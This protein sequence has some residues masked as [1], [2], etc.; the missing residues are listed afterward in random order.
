MKDRFCKKGRTL[1]AAMC[2]LATCGLTYSCSDDYDLDKTTPSWLGKS[3]Y[4]ELKAR[5]TFT[6]YVKL[7]DDLDYAE[8]LSKTGSK[9]LFVAND[10]AFNRFFANNANRTDDWKNA[11]SYDRLTTAQKKIILNSSMINNAYLMELMSNTSGSG[12]ATNT[13]TLISKGSC[14]RRESALAVTDSIPFFYGADLPYSYNSTDND[15]WA[16]FRSKGI[17]LAMDGTA[18]MMT[19]FLAAQMSAQGITDQDFQIITGKTRSASDAYIYGSK[20]IEQDITCQN[21]YI[22]VL[23]NVLVTPNN[24]AEVLRT[25]GQTSLFSHMVERFSAPFYNSTLTTSFKLN[26]HENVDSVFEKRYFSAMSQGTSGTAAATLQKDPNN[27]AVTS[28]LNFDP[29]WNQYRNTSATMEADMGA[30]FVPRD[31][32]LKKYFLTGGGKFLLDAYADETPYT[33]ANLLHNIDQIPLNVIQALLNNL[34][35]LSFISTVPSKFETVLDDAQDPMGLDI[36][37]VDTVLLA[38]NGALYLMNKVFT[39]AKYAAVSAPAYVGK[40]MH[41]FNWAINNGSTGTTDVLGINYYAYLLAMSSRFSLFIP[42]DDA[43]AVY[44]DPV[45][46]GYV[47]PRVYEFSFDTK[48]AYTSQIIVKARTYDPTTGEVGDYITSGSGIT[49]TG[50][51]STIVNNRLKD[52]LEA[53]T[54]IH[55]GNDTKTG[56]LN[57]N[58]WFLAKNGAPIYVN[59]PSNNAGWTVSGGW[60][61]DKQKPCNVTEVY[62]KTKETNGNGNGMTYAIDA[63][64]EATTRTVYN[65][66]NNNGSTEDNPYSKFLALCSVDADLL[67]DAGITTTSDQERY[68]IF[69]N[70]AKH[71]SLDFLVRFFNSY[72]YTIWAPTN[73]AIE[74]AEQNLGLPTWETIADSL[75]K[76]RDVD[77]DPNYQ[78]RAQAMI[79][80]LVNFVKYHFQDNSIFDD[81]NKIAA[82]DYETACMDTTRLKYFSVQVSS[83]GKGGLTVKDNTGKSYT[84]T[85]NSNVVAR[86]MK[87]NAAKTSA[88]TILTSSYAVIHQIDGCL[89]YKQLT[90]GRYDS[91]WKTAAS[92]RRYL[93]KYRIIK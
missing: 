38:N 29:G 74:D 32:V 90:N 61:I 78:I 25:N 64:I 55:E 65:V 75:A 88:T 87:L 9:T 19:H 35:K 83:T 23:D 3:I 47:Q 68:L 73:E 12:D 76:W 16:R 92:A 62:D 93:K 5:G 15:Y 91:D 24:M 21:G 80:S 60:Q 63:P 89:N 77:A 33:E 22:D 67:K 50:V 4:D 58:N 42:T 13:S 44:Y 70:D 84:V 18:P 37:Y 28:Y 17:T 86:D 31:D 85:G 1:L 34:M 72:N 40:N 20:V 56:I 57:G 41:I 53:H 69:I 82:A 43:L 10:D 11:T 30:I 27:N 8:V 46:M 66:F 39:P 45:S 71:Y 81:N 54:I 51:N 2:L 52:M 49:S 26:G 59:N 48:K 7:I 14:L 79:T 36:S 6:N